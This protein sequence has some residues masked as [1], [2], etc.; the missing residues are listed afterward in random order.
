MAKRRCIR[1][2]VTMFSTLT[3][4]VRVR[5]VLFVVFRVLRDIVVPAVGAAVLAVLGG[6]RKSPFS[7][8]RSIC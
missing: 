8:F 7:H 6:E 5:D 3:A 2:Y 1:L 4:V